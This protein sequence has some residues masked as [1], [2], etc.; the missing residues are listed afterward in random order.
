[1]EE[2]DYTVPNNGM[3]NYN[4]PENENNESAPDF[5]KQFPYA[6]NPQKYGKL[7]RNKIGSI[8]G[9]VV[10][11]TLA[12]TLIS[13][14]NFMIFHGNTNAIK[15]QVDKFPDFCIKDGELSMAE[16]FVYAYEDGDDGMYIYVS[17]DV[18]SCDLSDAQELYE[19][20]GYST[21]VLASRTNLVMESNGEYNTLVYKDLGKLVIDKQW[22]LQVLIPFFMIFVLIGYIVFFVGRTLW[23]FACAAFYM[24]VGM[25]CAAIFHKKFEAGVLFKT[26]VYAKVLMFVVVSILTVLPLNVEIPA[27]I[28]TMITLAMMIFAFQV[29]PQ[30]QNVQNQ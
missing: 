28:R 12:C 22:I 30:K 25:I 4:Q 7:V 5:F 26:A 2:F 13:A 3:G 15:E 24:L 8:I 16:D 10:L 20:D 27:F 11:L 1:M 23:Y 18:E 14:L 19:E 9:F 29:I 21:I 17:S 6:F